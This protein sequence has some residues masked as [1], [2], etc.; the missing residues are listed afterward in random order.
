MTGIK[1]TGIKHS[2]RTD[3]KDIPLELSL[4]VPFIKSRWVATL[5]KL[6]NRRKSS[7]TI[8]G[9]FFFFQKMIISA[10]MILK[11]GLLESKL[12]DS[13]S[14]NPFLYVRNQYRL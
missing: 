10:S 8:I 7:K 13:K 12:D 9:T 14:R 2:Y 1:A 5:K 11:N 4:K 6:L 3:K